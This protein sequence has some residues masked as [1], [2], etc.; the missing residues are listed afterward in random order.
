MI[1]ALAKLTIAGTV[2]IGAMTTA[3][4]ANT[5]AKVKQ[6]GEIVVGIKNDYK[7]W[8]Y[9]DPSGKNVGL[10]IDLANDVAKR[11][12]VKIELVPVTAANRMEFL[13]Q[14]RIDVII[15]T[16]S[17]LKERQK[18]VGMI[19]P[20]YYAGATNILAPKSAGLKTW[21]D[22][23]DKKVCAVGG[24]YYNR[25][26][27]KLYGPDLLVFPTTQDALNALQGGNCIAFLYDFALITSILSSDD[28]KW[29]NYEM[30][31]VSE[32]PQVWAMGVRLDDLNG[33]FGKFLKETSIEW[34]RSG[35]L[36][37]LEK[38]YGIK[39]SPYLLEMH[40]KLKDK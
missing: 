10:E 30:P 8:G 33:P 36:I 38:K 1:G 39:S 17:N 40:N 26:V 16:M 5:L 9:L 24:T 35:T 21:Q 31:L 25:R 27:D 3:Q 34:H 28:P 32:D 14:G 6:K 15:A 19:E 7:P 18:I 2:I 22:L 23:K 12:G 29:A 37:A 11:I 4:A 20:E 13:Q